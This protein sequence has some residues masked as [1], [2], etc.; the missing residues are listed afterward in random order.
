MDFLAYGDLFIG[1]FADVMLGAGVILLLMA[2]FGPRRVAA[3]QPV[4]S[5]RSAEQPKIDLEP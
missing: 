5:S 3:Q 1:N 2:T 4:E